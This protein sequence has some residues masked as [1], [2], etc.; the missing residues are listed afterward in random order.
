MDAMNSGQ[1]MVAETGQDSKTVADAGSGTAVERADFTPTGRFAPGN[2]FAWKAGESGNARGRR[3]SLVD[4]LQRLGAEDVGEG[5]TRNELL[6]WRA[7][8]VALD[9]K[10][11][12]SIFIQSL[13]FITERLHGKP[14]QA[15]DLAMTPE[16]ST[17]AE[18]EAALFEHRAEILQLLGEGQGSTEV[19]E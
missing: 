10:T 1:R 18:L 16:Q 4:Y 2:S 7:W 6:A 14:R 12:L 15:L 9:T 11:P 13:L 5:K 3:D 8:S 19:T 17:D